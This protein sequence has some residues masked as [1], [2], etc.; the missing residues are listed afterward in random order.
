MNASENLLPFKWL[1]PQY[2]NRECIISDSLD[3]QTSLK[4]K[5]YTYGELKNN[6]L[7]CASYFK[8]LDFRDRE[9]IPIVLKDRFQFMAVFFALLQNGALPVLLDP[10]GKSELDSVL[11]AVEPR[12]VIADSTNRQ[13]FEESA[14]NF[15]FRIID[16]DDIGIKE[17]GGFHL[18]GTYEADEPMC[19]L[20]TSGS[21]GE[22][23]GIVKTYGNIISELEV[24]IRIL[25]ISDRHIFLGLVPWHHIYGLLFTVF[26]PL[27]VGGAVHSKTPLLPQEI[28][29][30]LRKR[31]DFPTILVGVPVHYAALSRLGNKGKVSDF[32]QLSPISSGA[33]LS[34]DIFRDFFVTYGRGVLEI[35][36]STETGGIAWRI[37]DDE[38]GEM[39]SWSAFPYTEWKIK[40]GGAEGSLI[41]R[42]PAV[43]HAQLIRNHTVRIVSDDGWFIMGDIIRRNDKDESRF[44]FLGRDLQ[45]MKVGG[46][47]ISAR[48]I[49]QVILQ[50]DWVK[51]CAVVAEC[52]GGS[53][54]TELFAVIQKSR[55]V[56]DVSLKTRI[57][58]YCK[59][60]L[61]Q[62]KVPK[63]IAVMERIPRNRNGK[64]IYPE[65]KKSLS[66]VWKS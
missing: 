47:R 49:E 53:A 22:Q 50:I 39:T 33:A 51:D 43:S 18:S 3:E 44:I 60:K 40:S 23:S 55:Q 5:N 66:S 28:I 1:N 14:G 25:K 64:I 46:R 10:A 21:T 32:S 12:Y 48:E 37:Q 19:V 17:G 20:F 8:S 42:S 9:K 30:A 29:S 52:L 65:I 61:A 59:E 13:I 2:K 35:Y 6:I 38:A 15:D 24:L 56:D 54:G 57:R 16:P 41:V 62:Y 36:G 4:S 58:A 45:I 26:L 11:R 7:S 63:R 27:R 34:N 31:R